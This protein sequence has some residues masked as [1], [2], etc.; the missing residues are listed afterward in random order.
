MAAMAAAAGLP[1]LFTVSPDKTTIHPEKLG[2]R[3][4]FYAGCK[5]QN[6]KRWRE[7][8]RRYAPQ[9]LDHAAAILD[10][11]NPKV[12]YFFTTDTHWNSRAMALAVRQLASTLGSP[13]TPVLYAGEPYARDTD[14]RNRMLLLSGPE[15]DEGVTAFLTPREDTKPLLFIHDS[16]YGVAHEELAKAFPNS[17]FYDIE[18]DPDDYA[19]A[20]QHYSSQVVVNT[21]E[22]AL[23]RRFGNW[24]GA[25]ASAIVD[26]NMARAKSCVFT[27]PVDI[28][29]GATLENVERTGPSSFEATTDDPVMIVPIPA[30]SNCV[31]IALEV[32]KDNLFQL[33]LPV[34]QGRDDEEDFSEGRSIMVS[35]PAGKSV[36]NFVLPANRAGTTLRIDPTTTRGPFTLSEISFGNLP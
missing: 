27:Q 36:L 5:T 4:A 3:A 26:R 29:T 31:R 12:P 18:N 30:Q 25:L 13:S 2:T 20:L 28:D 35:L 16:F 7:L 19:E 11:G 8:A 6:G 34:L 17:K 21:V 9:L 1:I 24:D 14:L 33:F 32:D 23:F 15:A 22:R 10:P